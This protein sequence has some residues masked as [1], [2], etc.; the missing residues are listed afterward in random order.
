MEVL[1]YAFCLSA[2]EREIDCYVETTVYA[3]GGVTGASADVGDIASGNGGLIGGGVVGLGL[4]A[5][6]FPILGTIAAG[7][8][9]LFSN[10]DKESE[11]ESALANA[12]E[13]VLA[14]VRSQTAQQLES[15]SDR[16][17]AS[18]ADKVRAIKKDQAQTI[19]RIEAQLEKCTEE[20]KAQHQKISDDLKRIIL[21]AKPV[22][23]E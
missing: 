17:F 9:W 20:K 19:A 4:L 23:V 1:Y 10:S 13:Q 8:I 18:L 5:I 15:M 16:F 3:A 2:A 6:G 12:F 22:G 7:L 21:I 11:A 14:N